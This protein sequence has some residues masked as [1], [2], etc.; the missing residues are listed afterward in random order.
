MAHD[1]MPGQ[2][3]PSSEQKLAADAGVP[4]VGGAEDIAAAAAAWFTRAMIGEFGRP[5][6][7]Y[8]DQHP[9]KTPY[10]AAVE[11]ERAGLKPLDWQQTYLGLEGLL[12]LSYG[13]GGFTEIDARNIPWETFHR[14]LQNVA[15]SRRYGADAMDTFVNLAYGIGRTKVVTGTDGKK[16]L[17][18]APGKSDEFRQVWPLEPGEVGELLPPA[19]RWDVG[20]KIARVLRLVRP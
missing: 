6:N 14:A 2:E 11:A 17:Y 5:V 15:L 10:W 16:R 8:D 9:E 12:R 7:G 18:A 19:K 13:S 3:Q 1:G 4:R 20:P